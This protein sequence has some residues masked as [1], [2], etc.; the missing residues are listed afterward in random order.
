MRSRPALNYVRI[1]ASIFLVINV[2]ACKKKDLPTDYEPYVSVPVPNPYPIK[3][4]NGWELIATV[5]NSIVP[6]LKFKDEM[7][8][9]LISQKR[10]GTSTLLKTIDG[11]KSWKA[12]PISLELMRKMFIIENNIYLVPYDSYLLKI[13]SDTIFK[14]IKFDEFIDDVQFVN[15]DTGYVVGGKGLFWTVDGGNNWKKL[16]STNNARKGLS[17]LYFNS[18]NKGMVI[19]D[20]LYSIDTRTRK[21]IALS[22]VS[23]INYNSIQFYDEKYIFITTDYQYLRSEDGGKKF[24]K[25]SLV[26]GSI[27]GI[28]MPGISKGFLCD[29]GLIQ[30]SVDTGKTWNQSLKLS[31]GTI[32][33][34]N[35][36]NQNLGWACSS[37]GD[38][39]KYKN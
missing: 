28:Y 3:L 11:G 38:I 20:S 35:F 12:L 32:S 9:Y 14:K 7:N 13:T 16:L 23:E 15:I 29:A 31:G 25:S 17:A 27:L 5:Q 10:D 26:F 39:L 2:V 19:L 37:R 1:I 34:F 24:S 30:I 18:E 21:V 6:D 8:G 36:L 33:G 4:G 22:S